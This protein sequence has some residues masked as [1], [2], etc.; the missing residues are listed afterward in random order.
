MLRNGRLLAED[1]P[2]NLL[3]TYAEPGLEEVFLRLCHVDGAVLGDTNIGR[4][5][6]KGT[7]LRRFLIRKMSKFTL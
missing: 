7:V 5:T 4:Y 1:S 2:T 3:R 6:N